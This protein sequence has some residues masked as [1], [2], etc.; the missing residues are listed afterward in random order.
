MH[1]IAGTITNFQEGRSRLNLSAGYREELQGGR[2]FKT[3][4]NAEVDYLQWVSGPASI[5]LQIFHE[6][7]TIVD[8]VTNQQDPF[9]R[10]NTLL[11]LEW[12]GLGSLTGEFGYDTLDNSGNARQFFG[13]AIIVWDIVP[14]HIQTR[15]TAGTRRGGLRCVAGICRN[16]PP[17]A[18]VQNTLILRY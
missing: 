2:D 4:I 1:N 14:Q 6:S 3:L 8:P 12:N 16:F 15:L 11:S 18:G 9:N 7:R 5:H 10:G 13:A 17:F